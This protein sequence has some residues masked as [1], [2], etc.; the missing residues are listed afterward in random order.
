MPG[1]PAERERAEQRADR[2]QSLRGNSKQRKGSPWVGGHWSPTRP[3]LIDVGELRVTPRNASAPL[4]VPKQLTSGPESGLC[5]QLYAL[6]GYVMIAWGMFVE[7]HISGFVLPNFTS[8]DNGGQTVVWTALY[9]EQAFAQALANPKLKF[10][11]PIYAYAP[12][13]AMATAIRPK[14]IAGWWK[15]RHFRKAVK[16][17]RHGW[18]KMKTC[19]AGRMEQEVLDTVQRGLRPAPHIR[20]RILHAQKSMGLVAHTYGCVHARVEVDMFLSWNVNG[21]GRPPLLEEGYL[22]HMANFKEIRETGNI[23]VAVGVGISKTD[24]AVLARP[25][26]WGAQ[27]LRSTQG[28]AWHR[29]T[30]HNPNESSYTEAALVDFSICQE[31]KWFVGWWGS[32][33]AQMLASYEKIDHGRGW[34]SVCPDRMSYGTEWM[35]CMNASYFG[36]KDP[37]WYN[38]SRGATL[39]KQFPNRFHDRSQDGPEE[40][41]QFD[42]PF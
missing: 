6:A 29:R 18:F 34:Y 33:F 16:A 17:C 23:F 5:N 28:K 38:Y 27:M 39:K 24:D 1:R 9:E 26:S 11:M 19:D 32:T 41:A 2:G 7:G 10:R 36:K 35:S 4:F 30:H 20:R 22:T 40:L 8:H 3:A 12:D 21:A 31:S 15:F 37:S 42:V 13:G 25:T 14:S